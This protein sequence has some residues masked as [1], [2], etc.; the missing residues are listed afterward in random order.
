MG[1]QRGFMNPVIFL[2]S[3]GHD[4]LIEEF[5]NLKIWR[6]TGIQGRIENKMV[7]VKDIF[8]VSEKDVV[9]ICAPMVRYSK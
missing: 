3:N 6:D 9:K 5:T 2:A 8:A 1:G 7:D 4:V